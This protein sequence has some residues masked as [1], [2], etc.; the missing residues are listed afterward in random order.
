MQHP[1]NHFKKSVNRLVYLFIVCCSF[2]ITACNSGD[3]SQSGTAKTDTSDTA[4]QAQPQASA[5]LGSGKAAYLALK[6]DTLK[7]LFN[8]TGLNCKKV[9]FRFSTD[10]TPTSDIVIDGFP[11]GPN[12]NN[13]LH[14]KP[15]ILTPVSLLTFDLSNEKTY[16]S[17]L[18]LTRDQVRELLT[19]AGTN[20][21]L[22]FIPFRRTA[23]D[24]FTYCISYKL[25]WGNAD[26]FTDPGP[27][28]IAADQL[29]PSPPADPK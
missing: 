13:Y 6:I 16:L 1:N 21:H 22:I 23:A 29:N 24:A 7:N 26:S 14:R 4:S 3:T 10:G 28:F 19:T 2:G 12:V 18:E 27:G 17:D 8:P 20:T 9:V 11:T 5:F 25:V 15:V